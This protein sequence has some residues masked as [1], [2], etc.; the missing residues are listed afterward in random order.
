VLAGVPGLEARGRRLGALV[1]ALERARR[2][3]V[4]RYIASG[5]VGFVAPSDKRITQDIAIPRG[6]EGAARDN[7]IVVAEIVQ[8]PTYRTGPVGRVVE[9]LG[10]HMAPGM[11]IE[12]AIRAHDIPHK[13]PSDVLD[14]AGRFSA[15]V[16]AEA[17]QGRA[18][19]RELP[20]VT[21]D[22]EDA[23][24]FDDAVYAERQGRGWRL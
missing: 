9:V 11:E 24:D 4:G 15:E 1:E 21:I 12:G 13:W 6:A 14:E 19:L 18:D 5:G 17:Y 10:D 22:G 16:P 23:R 3:V 20:L 2:T 7:Q 8:P